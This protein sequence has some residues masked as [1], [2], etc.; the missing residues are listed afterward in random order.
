METKDR[1][2]AD[3]LS[4][5]DTEPAVA[6]V[7]PRAMPQVHPST[8]S[9]RRLTVR[10][11]RQKHAYTSR[12]V[13]SPGIIAAVAVA[14]PLAAAGNIRSY[15]SGVRAVLLKLTPPGD[16]QTAAPAETT[17]REYSLGCKI[18]ALQDDIPPRSIRV[19]THRSPLLP[20]RPILRS[21]L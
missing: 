11:Y 17:I 4:S 6:V 3:V 2:N 14:P 7:K 20:A 13:R 12:A 10:S 8:A 5:R 16:A 19:P 18:L 21:T 15:G 1:A 9:V